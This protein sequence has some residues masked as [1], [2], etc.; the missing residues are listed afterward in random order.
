MLEQ[1]GEESPRRRGRTGRICPSRSQASAPPE[2]R[3]ASRSSGALAGP[4]SNPKTRAGSS[5]STVRLAIPPRLR[6]ARRRP[7][8]SPPRRPNS[9]ASAIGESGA[10]SPPAATSRARKSEMTWTARPDRDHVAVADLERRPDRPGDAAVMIDRLAVR[11]DEV[12]VIG[13]DPG[14]LDR[15]QAG[16]G[17]RLADHDVQLGD[18]AD[19]EARRGRSPAASPRDRARARDSAAARPRPRPPAPSSGRR[20]RRSSRRSCRTSGPRR[21]AR[22]CGCVPGGRGADVHME[23]SSALTR[24]DRVR[25]GEDGLCGVGIKSIR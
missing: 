16:R 14:F 19:V 23:R 1:L 11:A 5:S 17:E 13:T 10:P 9:T 24:L 2:S 20:R 25:F 12:D 21:G 6:I 8:S 3:R 18:A 15:R 7:G 4:V 22:A